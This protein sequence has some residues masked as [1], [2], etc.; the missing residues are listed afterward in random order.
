M[1]QRVGER[2]EHQAQPI[3]EELVATRPGA[4]QIELGFLDA[5][6]CLAALAVE[7]VV[8]VGGRQV[9]VGDDEARVGPLCAVLQARHDT[10]R[11]VP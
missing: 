2:G 6:L 8:K 7:P 3:G 5:V 4:E 9:E 10:P 1:H 11:D